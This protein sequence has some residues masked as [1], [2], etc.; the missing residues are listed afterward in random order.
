MDFAALTFHAFAAEK[1]K[2]GFIYLGPIGDF[3]WTYRHEIGRQDMVKALGDKVATTYLENVPENA[4]AER[5]LEQ[6]VHSGHKLIFATSFGYMEPTLKVA[7]K[8][9]DVFFEHAVGFKRANNVS[10]YFARLGESG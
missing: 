7:A 4:D 8:Y 3:G 10:T 2:V 6:L 9:P 5:A 1:L